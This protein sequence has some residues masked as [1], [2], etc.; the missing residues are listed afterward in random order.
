MWYL[1]IIQRTN[2]YYVGITTDIAHRR[3]QHRV[4]EVLYQESFAS[5]KDA[6]ARERQIK[7]WSRRKK[8]S[9]LDIR[10]PLRR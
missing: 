10:K 1:Y 5:Q 8:E 6:A 2:R 9:I 4:A 7:E 3:G